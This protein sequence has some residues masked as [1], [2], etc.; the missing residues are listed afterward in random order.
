MVK[1]KKQIIGG[2]VFLGIVAIVSFIVNILTAG[3]GTICLIY[4]T[5]GIPCPTC[6]LTRSILYAM[7][8]QF[9]EAFLYHPLFWFAPIAILLL[10]YALLIDNKKLF[11]RSIIVIGAITIGVWIIRMV[12]FFPDVEP[13]VFRENSVYGFVYGLFKK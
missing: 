12:L 1:N 9:Q 5:T 13:M 8:L 4:N 11:H 3:E 10:G 6:G 7:M 2:L